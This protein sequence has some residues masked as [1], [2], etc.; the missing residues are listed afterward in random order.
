[1]K[2]PQCGYRY[3]GEIEEVLKA[4]YLL[5]AA[6]GEHMKASEKAEAMA[7]AIAVIQKLE[8]EHGAN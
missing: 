7:K 4:F 6:N 2:C 3:K 1:M 5:L 8:D